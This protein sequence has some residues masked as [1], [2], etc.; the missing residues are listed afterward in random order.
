QLSSALAHAHSLGV[1]HRDLKP[2]NIVASPDGQVKILDFGLA[3]ME[4]VE[5]GSARLGSSDLTSESVIRTVGTP[6]YIPPEH[7]TGAPVDERGDIYSLG[8]TLFELLTGRRPFE[9]KDGVRLAEAILTAPTP[10]PRALFAEVPADLD[11]AVYRAMARNPADRYAS[12]ADLEADLKRVSAAISDFPT[13]SRTWSFVR[14][15]GRRG[16]VRT[17]VAIVA[18]ALGLYG[19]ATAVRRFSGQ[20][21]AVAEATASA[22][23]VV[24]VLPLAGAAGDPQT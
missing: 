18:V 10:R 4:E 2:A 12:A 15:P 7:L 5:A 19:A 6:P 3:R 16:L 23:K 24:A 21:G 22:P 20:A 13:Q 8:V 14:R 17:A 9:A 11:A 1:I